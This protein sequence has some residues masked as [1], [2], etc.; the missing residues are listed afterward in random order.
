MRLLFIL[1]FLSSLSLSAQDN[2]IGIK[3]G[4]NIASLAGDG[5]ENTI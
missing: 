3:I 2:P 5:T 1:V 4:V